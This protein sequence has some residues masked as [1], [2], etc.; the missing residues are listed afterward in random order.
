MACLWLRYAAVHLVLIRPAFF[1]LL[2][3]AVD[4]LLLVIHHRR[5]ATPDLL[6]LFCA[7][8]LSSCT[9]R[10]AIIAGQLYLFRVRSCFGTTSH[11]RC[12]INVSEACKASTAVKRV[13]THHICHYLAQ[14]LQSYTRYLDIWPSLH[15]IDLSESL[16]FKHVWLSEAYPRSKSACAGGCTSQAQKSLQL[17]LSSSEMLSRTASYHCY[18][19]SLQSVTPQHNT[20]SQSHFSIWSILVRCFEGPHVTHLCATSCSPPEQTA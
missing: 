12:S 16:S 9:R 17:Q 20:S 10:H 15:G 19:A 3:S 11:C 4:N 7:G 2:S 5:A 13:S 8:G 14:S 6:V 1:L 18:A